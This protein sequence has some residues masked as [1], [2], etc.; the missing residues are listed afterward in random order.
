MLYLKYTRSRIAAFVDEL[1]KLSCAE[2]A[3]FDSRDACKTLQQVFRGELTALKGLDERD[4]PE[5]VKQRC[6]AALQKVVNHLRILGFILRSTNVRN[7]FEIFTPLLRLAC[8]MLE[9]NIPMSTTRKTRLILSSEWE[10]SPFTYRVPNLPGFVLIGFPASE[11]ENPLLIPLAG[12]ELGHAVW[13]HNTSL[14]RNISALIEISII[15]LIEQDIKQDIEKEKEY[16]EHLPALVLN[17]LGKLDKNDLFASK[18]LGGVG[19]LAIRQAQ[20]SFCDFIGLAIFGKSYLCAFSYLLSPNINRVRSSYYPSMGNRIQNLVKASKKYNVDVPTGYTDLFNDDQNQSMS[21]TDFLLLSLADRS[22]DQIVED[23]IQIVDDLIKA[24]SI[25]QSTSAEA[26]RIRSRL[27]QIVP[28][29]KAKGIADII[30]AAWELHDDPELW[31]DHPAISEKNKNQI[32][33][34]VVL[35]NIEIFE[36]EQRLIKI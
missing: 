10:F 8:A 12:H 7:A 35:K 20:E 29:E 9:P 17:D 11:A 16:R 19:P 34:D 6:V 21:D 26:E 27:R 32:F 4:N 14:E 24:T 31:N 36:I 25:V 15:E 13:H 30:N 23:I 28:A 33:R 18:V 22:L 5:A 2:F 3:Y 1:D